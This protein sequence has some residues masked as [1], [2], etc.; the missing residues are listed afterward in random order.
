M[1]GVQGKVNR[2]N[3][4]PKTYDPRTDRGL[5]QLR[6]DWGGYLPPPKYLKNETMQ[7]QTAN[8][9]QYKRLRSTVF[10]QAILGQVKNDVTGVKA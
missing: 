6:T 4:P 3:A 7:R 1:A 2:P 10:T 5:G 8:D 9:I